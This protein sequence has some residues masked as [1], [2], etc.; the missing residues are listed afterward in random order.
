MIED[1]S[2][3]RILFNKDITSAWS[4][5][6]CVCHTCEGMN[7]HNANDYT[8]KCM[9]TRTEGGACI[10]ACTH[11][12]THTRT[13]THTAVMHWQHKYTL[14]QRYILI[15]IFAH[16]RT[17]TQHATQWCTHT[18]NTH[19]YRYTDTYLVRSEYTRTRT[20]TRTRTH[21]INARTRTTQ[22]HTV[23]QTH[24][25]WDPSRWKYFKI[26]PDDLL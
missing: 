8:H 26:R 23:I 18:R 6:M 20:R 24:T 7:G 16:T 15:E 12:R 4:L 11:A 25:W 10:H 3:E 14:I 9:Y 21:H 5:C 1:C 19:T 13:N 2:G 17:H 22:K